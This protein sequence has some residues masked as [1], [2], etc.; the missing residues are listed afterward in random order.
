MSES[1][2]TAPTNPVRSAVQAAQTDSFDASRHTVAYYSELL[3]N[4]TERFSYTL[5]RTHR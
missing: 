3:G 4:L 5:E 1:T 2:R